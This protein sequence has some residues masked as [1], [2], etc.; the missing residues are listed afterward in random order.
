MIRNYIILFFAVGLVTACTAKLTAEKIDTGV[1]VDRPSIST[2]PSTPVA[3]A[4]TD[5]SK[6]VNLA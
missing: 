2:V 1:T 5:N 3:P 6:E 4:T